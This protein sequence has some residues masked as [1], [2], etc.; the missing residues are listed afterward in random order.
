MLQVKKSQRNNLVAVISKTSG[1]SFIFDGSRNVF[2]KCAGIS[3]NYWY[4]ADFQNNGVIEVVQ[5]DRYKMISVTDEKWNRLFQENSF[6]EIDLVENPFGSWLADKA[7]GIIQRRKAT[8]AFKKRLKAES[9]LDKAKEAEASAIAAVKKKPTR[10][11]AKKKMFFVS[12]YAGDEF[13][14]ATVTAANKTAAINIA[15]KGQKDFSLY[16]IEEGN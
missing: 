7:S 14:Q 13:H 6:E 15:K 11:A 8:K 12:F 9:Y 16:S 1:E 3:K 4:F 2:G 5:P 10:P